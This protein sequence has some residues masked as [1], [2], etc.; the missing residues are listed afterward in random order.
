M[1]PFPLCVSVQE[2]PGL[3]ISVALGNIVLVDHGRT[4]HEEN[5][6]TVPQSRLR[7]AAVPAGAQSCQ[8]AEG[9][10]IPARF[11]PALA[12]APLT[13][14]FDLEK[15]LDIASPQDE[16]WQPASAVIVRD[17]HDALPLITELKS[18]LESVP[19]FWTPRR[20]LLASDGNAPDFVVE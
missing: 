10:P 14:G 9:E 8:H 5:F 4:V 1:L 13:Q 7:L 20:D 2:Q 18:E 19:T 16:G 6:A 15:E 17:P 11:R 12:N 3:E